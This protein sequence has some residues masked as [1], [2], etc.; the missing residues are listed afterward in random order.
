M[1][2]FFWEQV[3]LNWWTIQNE[4]KAAQRKVKLD[5]NKQVI[6]DEPQRFWPSQKAQELEHTQEK[7]HDIQVSQRPG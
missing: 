4:N 3:L 2:G 5:A 1:I 6:S 7:E